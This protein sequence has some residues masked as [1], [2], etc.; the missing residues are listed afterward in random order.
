MRSKLERLVERGCLIE[1]R[2]GQVHAPP[3]P[4]RRRP[5]GARSSEIT[6]ARH[7]KATAHL[8]NAGLGAIGDP[9]FT[10]LEDDPDDP[11]IITGSGV[12]ASGRSPRPRRRRT[13]WSAGSGLPTSTASPT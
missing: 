10:G 2:A 1:M 7:H 12:P 6:T 9:G 13:S 4:G 11:V 8:R 3:L 5:S